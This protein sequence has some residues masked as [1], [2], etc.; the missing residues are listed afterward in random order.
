ML[1]CLCL[2]LAESSFCL[3]L[4]LKPKTFCH[5]TFCI[6]PLVPRHLKKVW[7]LINIVGINGLYYYQYVFERSPRGSTIKNVRHALLK[8]NENGKTNS[9]ASKLS[10]AGQ[11]RC[12]FQSK[13]FC[14]GNPLFSHNPLFTFYT[15]VSLLQN[16]KKRK[17]KNHNK[18]NLYKYFIYCSCFSD[19]FQV[20]NNTWLYAGFRLVKKPDYILVENVQG[21]E[22]SCCR[23][24]L[25]RVLKSLDFGLQVNYI[26]EIKCWF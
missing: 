7:N 24:E 13:Y 6:N 26:S 11:Q 3:K 25:L 20:S 19:V 23:T 5:F 2:V 9:I 17:Y 1:W 15:F 14:S 4:Y 21:F 22:K 18:T 16:Y 10:K 12:I 8:L